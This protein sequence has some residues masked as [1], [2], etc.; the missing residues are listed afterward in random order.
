MY[1]L[2]KRGRGE[3]GA[4]KVASGDLFRSS[5]GGVRALTAL[6]VCFV[7]YCFPVSC[8]HPRIRRHGTAL[9]RVRSCGTGL[10]S[11][12]NVNPRFLRTTITCFFC[13]FI[14][15]WEIEVGWCG[16]RRQKFARG[17]GQRYRFWM[18]NERAN[19]FCGQCSLACCSPWGHKES[20]M[21]EWTELSFCGTSS[22][23]WM[24]VIGN[25]LKF[26]IPVLWT[27]LS[28]CFLIT[29]FN[30]WRNSQFLKLQ[31]FISATCVTF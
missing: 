15:S 5:W 28:A 24:E 27:K 25:E 10:R 3:L 21:I 2:R 22:F 8:I 20:N 12:V 6:A 4:L 18:D 7:C 26:L 30:T 31:K 29:W 17:L 9:A 14:H 19:S 13:E 16:N 23:F 11:V 1:G